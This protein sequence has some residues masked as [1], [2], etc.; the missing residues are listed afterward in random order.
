MDWVK[1]ARALIDDIKDFVYDISIS[2]NEQSDNMKIYLNIETLE[3]NRLL[4]CM[5]SDGLHVIR[6]TLTMDGA[7]KDDEVRNHKKDHYETIYALLDNFSPMYRDKFCDI[8]KNKLISIE[9]IQ[10]LS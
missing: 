8:L 3:R 2:T 4:V 10:R 5:Y 7:F 1:E 9:E 6:E